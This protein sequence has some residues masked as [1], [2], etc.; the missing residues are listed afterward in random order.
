MDDPNLPW[1]TPDASRAG[2]RAP[3]RA[4][5]RA[6]RRAETGRMITLLGEALATQFGRLAASTDPPPAGWW[7][8]PHGQR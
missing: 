8:T 6:E 5:S 3:E 2:V 7:F 1:D 4:P